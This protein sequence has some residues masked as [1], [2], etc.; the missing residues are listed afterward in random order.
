MDRFLVF[1]QYD[2]PIEA[3]HFSL[4]ASFKTKKAAI[5]YARKRAGKYRIVDDTN[6]EI[7]KEWTLRK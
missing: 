4:I 1:R 7:V 5:E 6:N 2:A 3:G